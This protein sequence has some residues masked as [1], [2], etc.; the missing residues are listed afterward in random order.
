MPA[1][2]RVLIRRQW[3]LPEWMRRCPLRESTEGRRSSCA[4]AQGQRDVQAKVNPLAR[5]ELSVWGKEQ[6]DL[7]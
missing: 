5:L 3:L 4:D 2:G 6:Q 1:R 7:K